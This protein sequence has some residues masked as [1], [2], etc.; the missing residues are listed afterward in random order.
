[1]C[2]VSFV[3]TNQAFILTF[4]RD[5]RKGRISDPPAWQLREGSS[6]Y[7][8][9]DKEA[10]GTWIGYNKNIIACLQNGALIKHIRDIPYDSSRGTI[11]LN[12]LA[13]N[14]F[15]SFTDYITNHKIEPFTLSVYNINNE[16]LSI[17]RHDGDS[18]NIEHSN[19]KSSIMIC[20]CTLYNL[21][22]QQTIETAF[23]LI[24]KNPISIFDFHDER[25]IGGMKNQFTNLVDTV[26]ITQ[27]IFKDGKLR[28]QYFDVVK[29]E[30]SILL[31]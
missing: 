12:L 3:K 16:I 25:R 26:S 11:L 28:G 1:M 31:T 19:L 30:K 6:V 2:I 18:I 20:S 22:A 17:Y 24:E 23:N 13:N 29:N 4:N 27:F 21:D 15:K 14:D 8:P 10:G 5:E 7:C 9:L